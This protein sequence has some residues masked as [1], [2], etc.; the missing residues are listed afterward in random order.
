M[1]S[2]IFRRTVWPTSSDMAAS[3][4]RPDWE[5]GTNT[6]MPLTDTTMPPLLSSVTLPSTIS[7]LSCASSM[8]AQFFTASRRFLE[9]IAV[10]STSLTRTTL[11]SMVSPTCRTSSTLMP[12]SV[13]SLVGMKPEY[14]VP[15][16]TLI[17]VPEMATTVPVTF[18]PLYIG[19]RD[20][21]SISSKFSVSVGFS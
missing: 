6:R 8:E 4:G 3:F 19:L 5:A 12:S 13:N 17:S 11:A 7:P 21:S 18:S 1:T 15:I 16:S 2:V 20:A 9:S 10:P 14:L